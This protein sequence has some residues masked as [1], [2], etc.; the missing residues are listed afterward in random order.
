MA[1]LEWGSDRGPPGG[2]ERRRRRRV[3][4]PRRR[5]Q[6]QGAPTQRR[7]RLEMPPAHPQPERSP[8]RDQEAQRAEALRGAGPAVL[9][10]PPQPGSERLAAA[11][12]RPGR[13]RPLLMV[14]LLPE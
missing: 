3:V 5:A 7:G 14:P 13:A 10:A 4:I 2:E 12:R 6:A 9:P 11:T 1:G 8:P